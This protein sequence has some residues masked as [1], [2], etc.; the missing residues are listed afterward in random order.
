VYDLQIGATGGKTV[1]RAKTKGKWQVVVDGQPGP[2]YDQVI[3]VVLSADGKHVAY[4]AETGGKQQVVLD[5]Q[6]GPP[7]DTVFWLKMSHDGKHTAYYACTGDQYQA[8]VDGEAGPACKKIEDPEMSPDGGRVVYLALIDGGWRVVTDGQVR[9]VDGSASDLVMSSDGARLAYVVVKDKRYRVCVDGQLGP[10]YDEIQWLGFSRD[11]GRVGY[12]AKT[13]GK[14]HVV[15]DQSAGPSF[16]AVSGLVL[17]D[18]GTRFAY[19]ARQGGAQ[20]VMDGGGSWPELEGAYPLVFACGGQKLVAIANKSA[21]SPEGWRVYVDGGLLAT[22][23]R[24]LNSVNFRWL[25]SPGGSSLAVLGPSYVRKPDT[26]QFDLARYD[27]ALV[28]LEDGAV[29]EPGASLPPALD[30]T[31]AWTATGVLSALATRSD[32]LYRFEWTR[33]DAGQPPAAPAGGTAGTPPGTPLAV[34]PPTTKVLVSGFFFFGNIGEI[35]GSESERQRLESVLRSYGAAVDGWTDETTATIDGRTVKGRQ[36]VFRR[37]DPS[38]IPHL[39]N[40]LEFKPDPEAPGGRLRMHEFLSCTLDGFLQTASISA[41]IE[42]IVSFRVTQGARLFYVPGPNDPE[43]EVTVAP[44]GSVRFKI[45]L[46]KGQE[47]IYARTELGEVKRFIKVGLF[48]E[49]VSEV[50]EDEYRRSVGGGRTPPAETGQK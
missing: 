29:T 12:H 9:P 44:D 43:Q 13:A 4:I 28:D 41:G 32:G 31:W 50:A 37:L 36:L 38:V 24:G 6:V 11:G 2:E 40:E 46:L 17:S 34:S 35:R 25:L 1:Y 18:D 5:G 30:G 23:D 47:F 26:I 48:T 39:V 45:R 21:G 15:V 42:T 7:Y 22:I 33:S 8:V 16:D 14:W 49:Q 27:I 20:H 19:T 10:E 3:W